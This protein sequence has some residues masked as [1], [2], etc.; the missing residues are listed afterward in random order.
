MI[1]FLLALFLLLPAVMHAQDAV[2]LQTPRKPGSVLLEAPAEACR[3]AT[4]DDRPASRDNDRRFRFDAVAPGPH[5]LQCGGTVELY[6]L[7]GANVRVTL[8]PGAPPRFDGRGA[9]LNR[10][11]YAPRSMSTALLADLWAEDASVFVPVWKTAYDDDLR[12]MRRV[13]GTTAEFREREARRLQY[14]FAFGRVVHPYFHWRESDANAI[15]NT[16]QADTSLTTF[17]NGLALNDPRWMS[18][19]EHAMLVEAFVHEQARNLLAGDSALQRGDARWLRAEFQVATTLTD[20]SLRHRT[21]SRLLSTWVDDNGS[22]GIDS[23]YARWLT[24]GV[25]SA[26]RHRVDSLVAVD[27]GMRR[28]HAV[29]VYRTV[30]GV[31]LE[32]HVLRPLFVDSMAV[33]PVMLWFHGGSWNSGTWWHSP[34][35][36]SVLQQNGVTVVA[37][38]LRTANRF[39]GGPLDQVE[40]AIRAYEWVRSNADALR[41]DPQRVGVAGFS[42][43]AT[44]A[45]ILG[46]RGLSLPLDSLKTNTTALSTAAVGRQYPA[47][48]LAVGACVD[49]GGLGEDGYYRKMVGRRASVAEFTPL[50]AADTGQPP[51]LLVHAD[52]DEYCD[53]QRTRVFVERSQLAG[54]RTRLSEVAGAGHFFG[55]YYPP[56]QRQMRRDIE[57]ALMEWGWRARP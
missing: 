16:I 43:G 24:Y 44:L 57:N 2:V 25:D 8:A 32:A 55:F 52:G 36:L 1:G 7:D 10:Y 31:D 37:I 3:I 15:A 9:P 50:L 56:G 47:A 11:L 53:I 13:A 35:V 21:M 5:T 17:L 51:T 22:R 19:P 42:S 27:I 18:L 49:P 23:V 26:T 6:V 33:T 4:L 54:N 30:D 41:I 48:V 46:T 14:R 28:G 12:Q 40:D 38:D 39:D 20:S 34:G 45:L 29:R